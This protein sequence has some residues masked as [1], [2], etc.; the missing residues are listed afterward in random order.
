MEVRLADVQ[1][2]FNLIPKSRP[3]RAIYISTKNIEAIPQSKGKPLSV[4]FSGVRLY[5]SSVLNKHEMVVEYGDGGSPDYKTFT[6]KDH[7]TK[8]LI[9]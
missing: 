1:R 2:A 7:I 6:L 8:N 5:F 3:I 9:V 4:D